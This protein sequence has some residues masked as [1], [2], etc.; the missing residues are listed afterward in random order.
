[1]TQLE[2]RR[3]TLIQMIY[4]I[5]G[6]SDIIRGA[7]NP[8][9]TLGAQQIKGKFAGLR[10]E[11][12]KSKV[13]LFASQAA[14][15]K[16]EI[17]ARH[18]PA[19]M[20]AKLAQV[21][22][23]GEDP[24]QVQQALQLIKAEPDF[25]FRVE[26]QVD[27]M[28][29]L[30]LANEQQE[31]TEF[32]TMV[33]NF[34]REATAASQTNPLL[35][36]LFM[37]MLKFGVRG[38]RVGR[39]LEGKIDQTT[40]TLLQKLAQTQANPPPPKPTPEEVKLQIAQM[41]D[42]REREKLVVE[43]QNQQPEVAPDNSEQEKAVMQADFKRMQ[44][45]LS[46]RETEMRAALI[47]QTAKEKAVVDDLLMKLRELEFS[48]TE[49]VAKIENKAAAAEVVKAKQEVATEPAAEAA[50]AAEDSGESS[51][52][53]AQV[54]TSAIE[55]ANA[56]TKQ[57]LDTLAAVRGPRKVEI[58]TPSGAVYKGNVS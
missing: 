25:M 29:Q 31:K 1:M 21:D 43:Q 22:Q 2:A 20:I 51:A 28:V 16:M 26:V 18:F 38:F 34:I 32:L 6:I 46:A 14:A 57:T 39:S 42:K 52:A 37:E 7:T 41:E 35:G 9:E 11:Q 10:L 5:T 24:A 30:D 17:T 19:E 40:K 54:M 4:E 44:A 56:L 8:N 48:F 27:T 33:S 49:A 36:P 15:I 47:E 50:D 23:M 58:T 13:A 53:L 45:E 3:Q 12:R 55:Q